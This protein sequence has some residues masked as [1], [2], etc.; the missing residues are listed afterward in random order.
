MTSRDLQRVMLRRLLIAPLLAALLACAP[1]SAAAGGGGGDDVD[2]L[3][4]GDVH[5]PVLDKLR[6]VSDFDATRPS[7]VGKVKPRRYDVLITDADRLSHDELGDVAMVQ[8]F[9]AANGFVMILDTEPA[10]HAAIARYISFDLSAGAG[11]EGSEMV[12]VGNSDAGGP[13]EMLIVNSG[14]LLPEG[15]GAAPAAEVRELKELAARRAAIAARRPDRGRPN[16][17]RRSKVPRR[18]SPPGRP[19]SFR[20]RR[21][22]VPATSSSATSPPSTSTYHVDSTPQFSALPDGYWYAGALRLRKACQCPA[23]RR[24]AGSRMTSSTSTSTTTRARRATTR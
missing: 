11:G 10:D 18:P 3:L 14:N 16:Q 23:C 12:M 1:A 15:A 4:L 19:R 13:D 9:L 2:A 7:G 6:D 21:R 17:R 5:S 20:R 8:R 24:R 22:H